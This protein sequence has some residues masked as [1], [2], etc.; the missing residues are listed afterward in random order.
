MKKKI[1][2]LSVI[3]IFCIIGILGCSSKK[4]IVGTWAIETEDGPENEMIFYE[5]G[6]CIDTPVDYHSNKAEKYKIQEDGMLFFYTSY[7][8]TITYSRTESEE[9]ALDS[10]DVYYIS[11][12]TFIIHTLKY[13]KQ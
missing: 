10:Y 3:L 11:G 4:S 6:T 5:D 2:L 1:C 13:T 12:D 9:E 8:D 7:G